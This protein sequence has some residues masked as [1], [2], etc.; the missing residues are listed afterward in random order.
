M[1]GMNKLAQLK[2]INTKV[3]IAELH[4]AFNM[5]NE[6][7]FEGRL[8]EPAILIQ[9]RGNKKLTLGWCSV[10]KIWKNEKTEEEKY[11]INIV[12]EALNRGVYPV[13]TTL[14]HEM[15]HLHNLVNNIKDTSRGNT[16]H[17]MKFKKTAEAHGLLV[18]H[19][20]KI[21]WSVSKL[22]GLTMDLID[23]YEF[24]EAVFSLGRRDLDFEG[25]G[26]P[27]KK[28]KTSSRKYIC[29]KCGTSIRASK[30]V[31]IL[32]GDCTDIEKNIIVE[33]Y[34]EAS[35][36]DDA[37]EV[38]K[39]FVCLDCGCVHELPEGQVLCPECGGELQEMEQEEEPAEEPE[40]PE[41][42]AVEEPEEVPAGIV[43]IE[44]E[45]NDGAGNMIPVKQGMINVEEPERTDWSIE[46]IEKTMKILIEAFR[47]KGYKY[48]GIDEI[49]I[50]IS[51][52]LNSQWAKYV[53]GKKIVFSKNYLETA[54][55]SEIIDCINHQYLHH[56]QWEVEGLK[57]NHRKEFK[58]LCEQF[59]I[60]TKVPM[61]N[62][63]AMK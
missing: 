9:S 61:K 62:H 42:E 22:S 13:M 20:N 55:E 60:E 40:T 34:K 6:N 53:E 23:S 56:Y 29:P 50:E 49:E 18:E 51:E 14:L 48:A 54:S 27:R 12:A 46:Q 35:E 11:E 7:L 32:C 31:N 3:V 44:T 43:E 39:T 36:E 28:K 4:R 59:G 19:E 33:M 63:R 26:K 47:I 37:E 25:A 21:G 41:E 1:K 5:F 38:I 58:A 16:Y 24:D 2:N 17:N 45:L 30:D 8:P 52:K 10:Q 57:M 15:I